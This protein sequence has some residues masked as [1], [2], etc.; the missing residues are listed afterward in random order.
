MGVGVEEDNKMRTINSN[1]NN[2]HKME[3]RECVQNQRKENQ[4]KGVQHK[5]NNF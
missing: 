2:N 4:N 1:N 5:N 3:V